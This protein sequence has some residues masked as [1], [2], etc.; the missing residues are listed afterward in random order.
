PN[1]MAHHSRHAVTVIPGT[2]AHHSLILACIGALAAANAGRPGEDATCAVWIAP[3]LGAVLEASPLAGCMH[4]VHIEPVQM[5]ADGR[6]AFEWHPEPGNLA[7]ADA[8]T[9]ALQRR[10]DA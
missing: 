6:E 4:D 3:E 5:Q 7:F 9:A 8:H 1:G 2:R 10:A